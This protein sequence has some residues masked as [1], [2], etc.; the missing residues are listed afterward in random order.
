MSNSDLVAE[1]EK[2]AAIYAWEHFRYHAG[3]RQA[4]FR[5]YLTLIGAATLAYGYSRRG[6]NGVPS[7]PDQV[8]LFI[9]VIYMIGSFLFWR[10]D[11][12]SRILIQLAE[13][14]LKDSELKISK[15]LNSENIRLMQRADDI[16]TSRFPFSCFE[17]F[18]QIYSWIFILIATA[19]L[20]LILS[21][22]G[23]LGR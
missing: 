19:G 10:L 3:Q 7:N 13:A 4:V 22:L 23:L 5:F 21:S 12:R 1:A 8:T 11:R 2:S 16:K 17:S 9:G 20:T 15:I 14:A 18:R 6:I